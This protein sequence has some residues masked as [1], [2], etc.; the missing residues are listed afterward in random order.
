MRDIK[1]ILKLYRRPRTKW[2]KVKRILFPPK[3][4][5]EEYNVLLDQFILCI[6]E[7]HARYGK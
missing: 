2:Q 5:E 7:R 4:T 6:V 1:Q 3:L